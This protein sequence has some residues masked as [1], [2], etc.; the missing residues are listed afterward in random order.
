MY[1]TWIHKNHDVRFLE[2]CSSDAKD[3][4]YALKVILWRLCWKTSNTFLF[5]S[6][7]CWHFPSH[8]AGLG[9][10]G[11]QLGTI[12]VGQRSQST[13]TKVCSR[14]RP[15]PPAAFDVIQLLPC[16]DRVVEQ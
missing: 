15:T 16:Y 10:C 8:R 6:P 3:R 1:L 2:H 14:G 9:R 13:C 4:R 5:S 7:T 12:S 11:A